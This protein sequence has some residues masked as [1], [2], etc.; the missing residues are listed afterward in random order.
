MI[1]GVLVVLV[2][3]GILFIVGYIKEP[4]KVGGPCS[5]VTLVGDCK[6]TSVYDENLKLTADVWHYYDYGVLAVN[7]TFTPTQPMTGGTELGE[8]ERGVLINGI[9]REKY[10][11]TARWLAF[12]GIKCLL[13]PGMGVDDYFYRNVNESCHLTD[14]NVFNCDY[15]EITRQ[16][17]EKCNIKENAVIGCKLTKE[18]SGSCSPG[19]FEYYEP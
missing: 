9:T 10:S 1:L 2:V 19:G 14:N 5:Y 7:Y 12:N 16:D 11:T 17:L 18:I 6:I 13:K 3:I 15:V 8:I 4:V